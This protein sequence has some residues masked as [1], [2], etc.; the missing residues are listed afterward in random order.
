M[1]EVAHNGGDIGCLGS[2]DIGGLGG[3]AA[4]RAGGVDSALRGR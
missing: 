4:G 1:Q 3:N 2:G